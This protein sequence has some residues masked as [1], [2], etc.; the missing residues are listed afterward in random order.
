MQR[1]GITPSPSRSWLTLIATGSIAAANVTGLCHLLR[2]HS[3]LA[4]AVVPTRQA[5]RFV[6]EET[7]L[8]MGEADLVVSD[9]APA[10]GAAPN[11]VWLNRNSVATAIY[12]ASADF[13]G[14]VAHG[15]GV[16]FA[17]TVALGAFDKPILLV[18]SVNPE[19]WR[20]PLVQANLRTLR[21][22]GVSVADTV[23]GTAPPVSVVAELIL[24][25]VKP[26]LEAVAKG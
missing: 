21:S 19:M 5:L 13:I 16:D 22:V 3:A 20:N 12:P 9:Y 24:N 7:L 23:E 1:P 10:L 18:P 25:L 15:L 11:H 14:K 4:V 8:H 2:Q 17:S 6:T 26:R